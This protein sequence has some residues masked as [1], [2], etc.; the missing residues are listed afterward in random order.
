MV[1][2]TPVAIAILGEIVTLNGSASSDPD[3]TITSY[4]WD[5][6]D[7]T[8]GTGAV[9]S[10]IYAVAGTY[11]AALTVTDN[12]GATTIVTA[13]IIIQTTIQAINDLIVAVQNMN[14]AQGIMNSL[15]AKLQNS[16]A[17]LN[18]ENAGYRED[19]INKLQ[20]FV[21]ATQAQSGNKLTIEQANQLIAV[22]NRIIATLQ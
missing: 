9:V 14:L 13:T 7:G 20:A 4:Q 1:V 15:D 2:I 12:D 19:A 22:A 11:Q 8:S 16:I 3:G 6:G 10:H 18:A 21:S 17:A 5:F